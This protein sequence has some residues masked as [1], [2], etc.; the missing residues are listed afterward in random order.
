VLRRAALPLIAATTVAVAALPAQAASLG[1]PQTIRPCAGDTRAAASTDGTVWA[2]SSCGRESAITPD[3]L[4]PGAA[5]TRRADRSSGRVLAV[6]DDGRFTYTVRSYHGTE[7]QLSKTQ[8]DAGYFGI[9][10]LSRGASSYA[11][12]VVARGGRYWAVWSERVCATD[13]SDCRQRLFEQRSL[14]AAPAKK[15]LL[16]DASGSEAEP[17]LALRGDSVVLVFVRTVQGVRTLR[18]ATAGMDGVWTERELAVAS[19]A[20]A[21]LPDVTVSG[22]RT[23]VAWSRAGRP[24]LAIDDGRLEFATRRDLPYRAPVNRVAVAASGGRAFVGSAACF[25]YGASSTCRVYLAE[26]GLTGAVASA[27]ASEVARSDAR[28]ELE[29]VVAARGWATVLMDTGTALVSRVR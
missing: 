26:A 27:E 18:M 12:S 13:G 9:A 3:I 17:A 5:W 6:T 16:V 20:D 1:P 19:G 10:G 25:P 11:A 23:L 29:D 15:A 4:R 22:G 24:A 7:L 8:H 2:S 28:W 14:G 21:G